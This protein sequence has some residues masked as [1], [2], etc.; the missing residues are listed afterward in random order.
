MNKEIQKA[1][2]EQSSIVL[3]LNQW[4]SHGDILSSSVSM[5]IV[6]PDCAEGDCWMW[7]QITGNDFDIETSRY[8]G[9]R[10]NYNNIKNWLIR[11]NYKFENHEIVTGWG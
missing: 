9:A 5:E 6:T 2:T 1:L 8:V 11:N 7:E 3:L 4:D 10:A